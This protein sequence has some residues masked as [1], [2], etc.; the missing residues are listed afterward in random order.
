MFIGQIELKKDEFLHP[1]EARDLLVTFLNVPE[2]REKLTV[3]RSWRLQEGQELVGYGKVK[4]V[5]DE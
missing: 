2:L 5:V 1:G 3:G 4:R